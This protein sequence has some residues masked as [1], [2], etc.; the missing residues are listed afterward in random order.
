MEKKV[1]VFACWN[2]RSKF[3]VETDPDKRLKLTCKKC[4]LVF[5]GP[6]RIFSRLPK[7]GYKLQTP[8]RLSANIQGIKI[9]V[10]AQ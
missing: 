9:I 7:E 3:E 6:A 5:E 8:G 1:V 10:G 2:C 4:G